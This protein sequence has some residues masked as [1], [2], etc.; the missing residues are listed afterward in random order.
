M[1]GDTVSVIRP[2][3]YEEA[4]VAVRACGAR[5]AVA[6]GGPN[7]SHGDSA[8]NA[9]G[10]VLDMTGLDRVHVV[11]A[12]EG[13]V[14]CAAGVPLRRL[15]E[16]LL[17]LGWL[18]P[19]VPAARH[20]T[21][22]G[23]IAADL[24]VS[25]SFTRHVQ[26]L[27]LLTADGEVRAVRPDTELFEAT[28]GG[29]GLTGVILTATIRLL[30]VQTA[31]LSVGTERAA[32]LDDLLA[33]L[34]AT[35]RGNRYAAA[36]I[37]LT[38]RGAA[39][40]RGVLTRAEPAPLDALGTGTRA[41][42]RLLPPRPLRLP[43]V[44]TLVPA[45]IRYRSAPRARTG[46]LRHLSAFFHPLDTV[47]LESR[48][49]GRTGRVRY[50][51]T[52]GDGQEETL[53]RIVRRLATRRCPT[54]HA[55]L[56]RPGEAGPGWLSC[57]VPGWTLTLDLPAGLPKLPAFLDALDEEVAAAGGRVGLAED[58]RLRPDLFTAMYPRAA[59]FRALRAGLDPRAVFASD[60]ARRLAL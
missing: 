11:D 18:V 6:R 3:T 52:V 37:D 21:V 49:H 13:V 22:G 17:P 60:L 44:G 8:R 4:A 38:A 34:T 50:R 53:H 57:A 45:S 14:L 46:A 51:F 48:L 26:A 40:G 12:D 5:G 7:R 23:A 24:H 59:D 55:V 2:R 16:L 58:A 47:P 56:Q 43:P 20:T 36:R 33:R 19:A 1:S 31:Y 27:E 9:G 28:A 54:A 35:G 39:T 25:G 30:P 41:W 32:G 10:T 42:R 29:L 15:A